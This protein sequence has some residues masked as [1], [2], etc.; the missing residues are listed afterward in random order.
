MHRAERGTYL[1]VTRTSVQVQ[2]DVHDFSIIGEKVGEVLFRGFFVYIGHDDD[3][4]LDRCR[5]GRVKRAQRW[6]MSGDVGAGR[7]GGERAYIVQRRC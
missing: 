5:M 2:V 4:S 3:P 6:S 1:D 7:A